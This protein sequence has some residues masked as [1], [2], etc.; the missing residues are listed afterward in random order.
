MEKAHQLARKIDGYIY[1]ETENGGTNTIYVSPVPF[2]VLDQAI[3]K[4]PGSPHLAPAPDAMASANKMALALAI[5][6]VAGVAG[7]VARFM[8]L[9]KADGGGKETQHGR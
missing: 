6:P 9:G 4:G 3:E 7:A 1:G 2:D 5:A 8:S